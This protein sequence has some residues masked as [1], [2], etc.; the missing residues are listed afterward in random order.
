[1]SATTPHIST[2]SASPTLRDI[3]FPTTFHFQRRGNT[4]QALGEPPDFRQELDTLLE[5][6][7]WR[8]TREHHTSVPD[9]THSEIP[10]H[11]TAIA[12]DT[13]THILRPAWHLS[14]LISPCGSGQLC[15]FWGAISAIE[16]ELLTWTRPY[17]LKSSS[18]SSLSASCP[19]R[20]RCRSWMFNG[21]IF[22]KMS[23]SACARAVFG[24]R[25]VSV[26]AS[27]PRFQPSQAAQQHA[28]LTTTTTTTTQHGKRHPLTSSYPLNTIICLNVRG[29]GSSA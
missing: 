3:P 26:S 16:L 23:L 22:S 2:T 17:L 19:R 6:E 8:T 28:L 13:H 1:M 12:Q 11:H 29:P 10:D 9:K 20:S 14:C 27:S 21:A 18:V 25:I 4:H 5:H 24:F 7:L 15:V